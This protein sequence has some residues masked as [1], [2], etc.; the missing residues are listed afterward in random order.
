MLAKGSKQAVAAAMKGSE[1][2]AFVVIIS[3]YT[4]LAH[5]DNT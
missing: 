3:I 2:I 4:G 1:N 5:N